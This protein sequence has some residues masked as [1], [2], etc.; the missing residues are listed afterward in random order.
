MKKSDLK[1]I[2]WTR[3]NRNR[4]VLI[5]LGFAVLPGVVFW[6]KRLLTPSDTTISAYYAGF[7]QSLTDVGMDGVYS[8][9][10]VCAPYI[11][12]DVFLLIKGGSNRKP[13]KA[14]KKKAQRVC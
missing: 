4:F 3:Q 14:E 12:Y 13:E 5:I 1:K 2:V 11:A 10:V 9:G 6:L 8:W 7:Y